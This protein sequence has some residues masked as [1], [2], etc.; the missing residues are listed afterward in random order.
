MR[1]SR[2]SMPSLRELQL[3]FVAALY[4]EA[5]PPPDCAGEQAA[6]RLDIYRDNLRGAFAK[7]L[8]LE[9]PVVEKLL[10]TEQFA[11]LAAD[12]QQAQPSRSGDL[13]HVGAAFA[14]YVAQRCAGTPHARCAA[15]AEL[16]WALQEAA[17][18]ADAAALQPAQLRGLDPHDYGELRLR[19]HPACRLLRSRHPVQALWEAAMDPAAPVAS[20][21]PDGGE[22]LLVRRAP[23]GVVVDRLD[24]G[25]WALLAALADGQTLGI[26]LEAA[27]AAEAGFDL[28]AC[29]QRCIARGLLAGGAVQAASDSFCGRPIA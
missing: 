29:L 11:A 20:T 4:G 17:L 8:R 23:Q 6:Q 27:L 19:L 12:Y 15:V 13:Q 25:E 24:A 22:L 1:S 2:G 21:A 10:G 14:S 9:F 16:E 3:G 26:A 7:A 5:G 18:A 28:T